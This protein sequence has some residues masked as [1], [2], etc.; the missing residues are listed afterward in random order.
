MR[1]LRQGD[2]DEVD[3]ETEDDG[4]D[5]CDGDDRDDDDDRR[6]VDVA[7]KTT[8]RVA[9]RSVKRALDVVEA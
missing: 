9:M 2:D 8:T 3:D 5:D 4:E 1:R 7:T 6:N